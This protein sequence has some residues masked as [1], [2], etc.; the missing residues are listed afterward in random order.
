[1]SFSLVPTINSF[2]LSFEF[3]SIEGR[4]E[5]ITTTN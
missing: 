2:I 1:V 5:K 4:H 3:L